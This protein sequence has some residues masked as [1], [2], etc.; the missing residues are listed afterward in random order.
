[1]GE[2]A[3]K[4]GAAWANV[5]SLPRQ[6]DAVLTRQPVTPSPFL[7]WQRRDSDMASSTPLLCGVLNDG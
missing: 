4:L 3:G 1:M 5:D 2:E 6:A 7:G